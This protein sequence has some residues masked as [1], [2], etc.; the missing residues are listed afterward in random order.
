MLFFSITGH[1]R[2]ELTEKISVINKLINNSFWEYPIN[3]CIVNCNGME[4][5]RKMQDENKSRKVQF[6]DVFRF[7]QSFYIFSLTFQNK[8]K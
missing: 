4:R 8:Q 3:Y 5:K 2:K 7:Q 6:S 1:E